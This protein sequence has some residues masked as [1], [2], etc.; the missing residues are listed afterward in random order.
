[1]NNINGIIKKILIIFLFPICLYSQ[2][3]NEN[4]E[5]FKELYSKM[6]E[7]YSSIYPKS[8][9]AHIEGKI[10]EMQ[11]SAIP[12]KNYTSSKD[13]IK[14]KFSFTQGTKPVMTLENVDSFYKN[15]FS[16]FEG[17]LET[18]GFYAVV[19]NAQNF[20]SFSDKFNFEDLKEEN[21]N[22]KV[23]LRAK[24]D[25]KDY[26]VNYEI[27]KEN[28]LIEKVQYY[29]KKSKIYDVEI[30]YINLEQYT[31]PEIIKYKSSDGAVS[32]EIKFTD[33]KTL[34]K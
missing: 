1:M 28:L 25:D 15:M 21:E 32:S 4:K 11:I 33:I 18:T 34:S 14:L 6:K 30:F 16:I 10:V 22:Y 20:N 7:K 29:N 31:L 9:E 12:E 13:K 23:I 8:F 3:N 17:V 27:N 5:N 24:G 19:G 2:N 26:S